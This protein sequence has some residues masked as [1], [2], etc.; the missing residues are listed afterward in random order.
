MK[1]FSTMINENLTP[2]AKQKWE[3]VDWIE[4]P[5]GSRLN[6]NELLNEQNKAYV[7]VTHIFPW[8]KGALSKLKVIYT[9]KVDTQATDGVHL[10]VNP[11]FTN[12]LTY[13]QKIFVTLH[14]LMH[15][16]FQHLRRERAAGMTDHMRANI[17]ADHEVN[18]AL[19]H[20]K[21]LSYN[22]IKDMGACIDQKYENWSFERIY[23]D[24]PTMN[25]QPAPKQQQGQSGSQQGQ[26]GSQQS[27]SSSQQSQSSSQQGQSGS[28]Q[29][30]SSSQQRQSSSQQGQSSSGSNTYKDENGDI[31]RKVTKE[32]T[33]SPLSES[34]QTAGTY[35]DSKTGDKI[36]KEEG[37]DESTPSESSIES[38]W[39]KEAEAI[40]NNI[41]DKMG[42]LS[43]VLNDIAKSKKNWRKILR[44]I[45]GLALSST[46]T[47]Y[48]YTNKN[49]L[50]T[51][52]RLA[53]ADKP[54]ENVTNYITC[55]VDTSGSMTVELMRKCLGEVYGLATQKRPEKLLVT[56]CDTHIQDVKIYNNMKEFDRGIK[57]VRI[58]G[59]GGTDFKDFWKFLKSQGKGYTNDKIIQS[60]LATPT[61]LAI[62]FTDGYV[63]QIP[64]DKN[65]MK[66]LIWVV[67]DN[68]RFVLYDKKDMKT[69]VIYLNTKE[70]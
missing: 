51:Q 33:K 45:V 55:M 29:S 63:D 7:G 37:Y 59:G 42:N 20:V 4:L 10:F 67:L 44:Q 13:E 28:Q 18:L 21:P 12:N 47:E 6:M 9:F 14:E 43:Q 62:I 11:Q 3:D 60:T 40:S 52:G 34:G 46:A 2:I 53:R 22:L 32:D 54:K 58:A 64:R 61:D 8:L 27:Q 65:T 50:A 15:N 25:G 23:A 48:R 5:D 35:T 16:I 19:S 38:E 26:S 31:I 1:N 70:M 36:A 39:R 24:N 17:A 56:Q 41:G 69:K 57:N 66:Y 30:Q 68:T 49:I